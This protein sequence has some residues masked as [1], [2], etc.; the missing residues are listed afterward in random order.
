M[1][2]AA[3]PGHRESQVTSLVDLAWFLAAPI[4]VW[5]Q[6][7]SGRALA[8]AVGR[9]RVPS[10]RQERCPATEM[11]RDPGLREACLVH[12]KRDLG[13]GPK[14]SFPGDPFPES[15]LVPVS[16]PVGLRSPAN[17]ATGGTWKGTAG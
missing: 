12:R 15:R 14:L 4:A 5:V 3:T 8:E 16:P 11:P 6:E 2:E 10:D 7:A 9:S 13:P 1:A 17:L